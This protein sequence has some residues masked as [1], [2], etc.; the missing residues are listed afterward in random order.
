[1]TSPDLLAARFRSLELFRDLRALPGAWTIVRVDGRGFSRLTEQRFEKPFDARVHAAMLAVARALLRDLGGAYAHTHSDEASL[2]IAPD[3]APFGGRVE[4]LASLAAGVASATFTHATGGAAT[5]DA[6]VALAAREDDVVDYLRWRQADAARAGLQSLCYWTLRA[7][8]TSARAA[9]AALHAKSSTAQ[10]ALL[11]GRG[12]DV[13]ARPAWQTRGADLHEELRAHEG[14]DPR[15]G[16]RVATTRRRLH[17]DED[18]PRGAAYAERV[19]A[20]L[21]A[22][23]RRP[24]DA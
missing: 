16:A 14:V 12:V 13:D 7:S 4:K 23:L 19:R 21:R 5:F 22:A 18:L 15:S 8:G 1:M 2:V 24:G 11:A 17:V 6:R 9:T 3:R 10:R 20:A